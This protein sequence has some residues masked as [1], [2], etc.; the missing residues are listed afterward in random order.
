MTQTLHIIYDVRSAIRHAC[1]LL[2]AGGILLCTIPAVS[3]V[4]YEDGERVDYWRMTAACVRRL[5][6]EAFG[7]EGITVET[8]GKRSNVRGFPLRPSG[9]RTRPARSR[10]TTIRGSH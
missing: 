5:F 10:C 9:R 1:R 7:E 4:N 8:Y 2:R 6:R 3:R